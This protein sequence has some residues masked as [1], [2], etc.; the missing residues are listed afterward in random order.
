MVGWNGAVDGPT[1]PCELVPLVR[2]A[3]PLREPDEDAAE[4]IVDFEELKRQ[5]EYSEKR[6]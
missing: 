2:G 6:R 4:L 1:S 3:R 5:Q